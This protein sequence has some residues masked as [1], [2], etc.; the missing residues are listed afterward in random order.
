MNIWMLA[1]QLLLFDLFQASLVVGIWAF[2]F[3][4]GHLY[5]FRQEMQEFR[6]VEQPT[7]P[8]FLDSQRFFGCNGID[9]CCAAQA[10]WQDA[11]RCDTAG[12]PNVWMHP[13]EYLGGGFNFLWYFHPECWE[14]WTHFDEHI[15]SNG[16][17][18]PPT[19]Y[20]SIRVI[21]HSWNWLC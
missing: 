13:S 2:P 9:D 11:W 5:G 14:R 15:F 4:L 18:Q 19:S 17:V 6:K 7:W 21:M 12:W 10:T 3:F 1:F 16:L 20:E 8:G